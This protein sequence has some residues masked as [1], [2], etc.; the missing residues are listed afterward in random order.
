MAEATRLRVSAQFADDAALLA[1]ACRLRAA[2]FARLEAYTPYP[3]PALG[4]LTGRASR[5]PAIAF[6]GGLAGFALGLGLQL[7]ATIIGYPLDVGGRPLDSW[8]MYL[9]TVYEFVVGSAVLAA[10]LGFILTA[11]L[12]RYHHP[13][14]EAPGFA[15]ASSD[16]FFLLVGLPDRARYQSLHEELARCRP[17]A[18]ADLPA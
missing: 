14:F 12:P 6:L 1:A 17:L 2:G 11:R 8:P 7:Y 9:P 13:A 15:R 5:V 16:G 4:A 18:V 3:V 10:T